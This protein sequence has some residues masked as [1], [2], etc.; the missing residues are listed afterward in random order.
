[1]TT[2][3]ITE[4]RESTINAAAGLWEGEDLPDW[5]ENEYLRG[6][7]EL[8][9]DTFG[10]PFTERV[11]WEEV[12]DYYASRIRM[13]VDERATKSGPCEWGHADR[14]CPHDDIEGAS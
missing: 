8:L 2:I 12:K 14:P 7:V 11:D 3:T 4:A 13:E 5:R 6:Q 1:M 10:T 9:A